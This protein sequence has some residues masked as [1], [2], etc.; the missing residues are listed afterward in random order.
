MNMC[1]NAKEIS[2]VIYLNPGLIDDV[3][4][5]PCSCTITSSGAGDY[6]SEL[7]TVPGSSSCGA[8]LE[9]VSFVNVDDPIP[10]EADCVYSTPF[11]FTSE[12]LEASDTFNEVITISAITQNVNST[13]FCVLLQLLSSK[14]LLL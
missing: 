14:Y 1:D 11:D 6:T 2:S 3:T 13:Q 7:R 10:N 9:S 8:K 5:L 12:I 4:Q